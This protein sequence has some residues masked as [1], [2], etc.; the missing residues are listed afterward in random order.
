MHDEKQRQIAHEC[1]NHGRDHNVCVAKPQ[2]LG[3]DKGRR[4]H[5]R[6]HQLTVYA[7]GHLDRAGFGA[8]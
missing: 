3:D 2:K 4:A 1:G 5:N 6:R 7:R 8:G